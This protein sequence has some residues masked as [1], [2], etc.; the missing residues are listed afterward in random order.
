MISLPFVDRSVSMSVI[1]L[2]MPVGPSPAQN[3]DQVAR[4]EL[5]LHFDIAVGPEINLVAAEGVAAD[6]Q[7]VAGP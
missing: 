6:V 4:I 1:T 2:P 3:I 5:G 7:R